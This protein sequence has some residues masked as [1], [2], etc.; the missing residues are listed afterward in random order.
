MG[1]MGLAGGVILVL[2]LVTV[3][4][5]ASSSGGSRMGMMAY[6]DP[7]RGPAAD[8]TP[9]QTLPESERTYMRAILK[10]FPDLT[11]QD[12]R[13]IEQLGYRRPQVS[14]LLQQIIR[15]VDPTYTFYGPR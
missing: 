6:V 10:T 8:L 14:P 9:I 1:T 2:V 5:S 11:A 4:A 13:A 12:L 7:V 15:Y 3:A